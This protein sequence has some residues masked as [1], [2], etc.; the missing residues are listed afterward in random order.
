[1][2]EPAVEEEPLLELCRGSKG[3]LPAPVNMLH[4]SSTA[5]IPFTHA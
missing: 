4:E 5:V 1:M 3:M 2:S